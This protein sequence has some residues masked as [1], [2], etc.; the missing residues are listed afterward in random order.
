MENNTISY[1]KTDENRILNETTIRWVKKMGECLE[2]CNK[3]SGC[4]IKTG[5]THKI[6]RLNSRDSYE[7]L[8][9]FFE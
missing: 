9:K 8:N 2:V 7:K 5:G 4:N 3:S 1:I 6:C